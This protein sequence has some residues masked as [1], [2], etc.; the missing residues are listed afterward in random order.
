MVKDYIHK[1]SQFGPAQ[2]RESA[3]RTLNDHS[4]DG[5]L[6]GFTSAAD[7][8]LHCIQEKIDAFKEKMKGSGL[9]KAE[10]AIYVQ[11]EELKSE[12]EADYEFYW[13][14]TSDA[15]RPS[16]SVVKGAVRPAEEPQP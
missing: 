7:I 1:A 10:Q 15:S 11:L 4:D 8:A 3:Q 12:I 6:R 13:H 2:F 9:N 5:H 16:S 14:D